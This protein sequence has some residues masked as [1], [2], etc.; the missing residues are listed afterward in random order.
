MF[1]SLPK[2]HRYSQYKNQTL[3]WL[4]TDEE[5]VYHRNIKDAVKR[6]QLEKCGFTSPNCITYKF[7]SSGFRSNEFTDA[8]GFIALGCS[9]TVGIGLPIDQVWPS[10]V[11][12]R[13]GLAA[14]N[15]GIGGG[16]M[17]TCF[18]LLDGYIEELKPKFVMLLRPAASRFEIYDH[19]GVKN[20]LPNMDPG[21]E[22]PEL[23][24][25]WYAYDQNQIINFY[26]NTIAITHLCNMHNVKLIIK[27]SKADLSIN[28]SPDA[29]PAARDLSH[30]GHASH[31]W[32]AE[33][34][35][36]DL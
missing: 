23:Q 10:L 15:L 12:E 5:S 24:K 35:L 22:H 19:L 27:D 18:R 32:C 34:F 11:S 9:Y 29:Y 8:P 26:K 13:T 31:I 16:S 7:N 17:D 1:M 28:P 21:S 4:D 6:Q 33:R 25:L 30:S 36:K 2:E 20:I 14:W 3:L